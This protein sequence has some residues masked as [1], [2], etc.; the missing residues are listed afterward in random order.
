VEADTAFFQVHRGAVF[1]HQ[2][3]SYVIS[4]LDLESRMAYAGAKKTDYYTQTRDI[5]DLKIIN[6]RRVK[7]T[8]TVDV[9]MGDV[10]VTT[11]VLG[12]KKKARY[13]EEVVGEEGLELPPQTFFTVALWFDLPK[14]AV[15]AIDAAGQDYAGA[16]HATEHAAI[17]VLSPGILLAQAIGRVGCLFNGCC[18][19]EATD[20]FCAIVYTNPETLG[21]LGIPVHPTQ[22][23]EIIYNLAVFGLL[24]WLRGRFKPAGSLFAIY[25][26]LY[27]VWRIGLAFLRE[28]T[29]FFLGL[30]QAQVISA[31]ILIICGVFIALKTRP[32]KREND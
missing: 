1:L 8:G 27:S 10:E 9:Y 30:N 4:K 5:T 11:T 28:G 29:P 31:V 16:L 21:P 17:G 13:T 26:A 3:E 6:R 14:E 2:G 25:L 22:V 12:F 18:Y 32:V 23:Y 7:R 19:G 15:S 20:I 24:F